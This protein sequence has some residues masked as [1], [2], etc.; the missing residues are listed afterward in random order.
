[1][2]LS[3]KLA[4]TKPKP[5]TKWKAMSAIRPAEGEMKKKEAAEARVTAAKPNSASASAVAHVASAV[6]T[7]DFAAAGT[8]S[9]AMPKTPSVQR[10]TPRKSRPSHAHEADQ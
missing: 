8:N 7:N 4:M 10:S 2:K 1:M 6:P 3:T 9:P 5:V